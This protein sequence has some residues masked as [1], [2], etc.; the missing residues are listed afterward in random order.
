MTRR[1]RLE[2]R[3]EKRREWSDSRSAKSS[4]SFERAQSI[5]D[6]I[7]FGQPILV[8]HHS[9]R[10]HRRDIARIESGMAA[11]IEHGR[12]A[13]AHAEKA[14]GIEEQLARSIYS[15]DVDAVERL[16][17]R[18][19]GLEAERER[20]KAYNASCRRGAR[21]VSLLDEKQQA[22]LASTA[23]V[24]SWQIGS[25]GEAPAYW[26]QNLGGNIRRNRERLEQIKREN[27]ARASGS[28]GR[29]RPMSARFSSTC[30]DCGE[31]IERGSQIVYYR[32][33]K[34]ATHADCSTD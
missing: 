5:A 33:T 12:K 25:K 15:D 19:A 34:E 22:D 4:A 27:A 31:T 3:A 11:G 18:I 20:I 17:E 29:G 16:E 1:E 21:D 9:E 30:A 6:G 2:R 7:P 14:E 8:G 23:R 24:C 13:E 32:L 28:R 26:L 10:A